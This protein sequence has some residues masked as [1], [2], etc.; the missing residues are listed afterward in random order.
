M[1]VA[2]LVSWD[3]L[4]KDIRAKSLLENLAKELK[5][6][7]IEVSFFDP[8]ADK[9]RDVDLIHVFSFVDLEMWASLADFHRPLLVTPSLQAVPKPLPDRLWL[10]LLRGI[11]Q[12]RWPPLDR[13][14]W[15]LAPT[16]FLVPDKS[17]IQWLLHQWGVPSLKLYEVQWTGAALKSAYERLREGPK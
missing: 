7:A 17:W 12:L 13:R 3:F 10:R 16:A 2:F 6:L 14:A 8:F 1:K 11:S 9:L 15:C 5:L 4:E